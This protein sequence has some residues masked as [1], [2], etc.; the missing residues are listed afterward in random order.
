MLVVI[1]YILL[2]GVNAKYVIEEYL[3]NEY[4]ASSKAR[5]DVSRFVLQNGFCSLFKNDKSVR[6][7]GKFGKALLTACLIIKL[8]K[9]KRTDILFVQ[10][11]LIVLRYILRVKSVK[12]FKVIYLIHD[13]YSLRFNIPQSIKEHAAEIEK[14]MGMLS[15]CDYVIA[16]ND[17]MVKKLKDFGC[18]SHLVPLKIFDYDCHFPEHRRHLCEKEK[19]R[20]VFAGYL[21]K[22][23]FL[24]E[25][26]KKRQKLY[27]LIIYGAPEIPLTNST[28][29]GC[30]D[31]DE[32]PNVI[33]GHFGLIWEGKYEANE[34]D[35]YSC[36][37]NPH[38]LSMYIV[39]GLPVIVWDKSA[40][41]Q[42]VKSNNIGVTISSLDELDDL[43]KYISPKEYDVMVTNC[44]EISKKLIK[45]FYLQEAM[46]SIL[47]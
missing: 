46:R 31:A 47:S 29:M 42:F 9:L 37:N 21:A 45:G 8:F 43:V 26:D 27:S 34:R 12:N 40:V 25:L 22:A 41:A 1:I 39:A 6:N 24:K 13:L 44:L 30:I 11:S 19:I 32:L 20:I 28:Y 7:H 2:I 36:V 17:T 16:H 23:D 38:K 33:E 15:R 35:N 10:S 14:D 4:N 3:M 5:K 18:T